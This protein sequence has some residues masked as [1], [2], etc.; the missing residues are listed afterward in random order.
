MNTCMRE[1]KELGKFRE[2]YQI[3]RKGGTWKEK[4]KKNEMKEG[5]NA[6]KN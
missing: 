3:E 2:Q 6:R 4:R 5:F 1:A